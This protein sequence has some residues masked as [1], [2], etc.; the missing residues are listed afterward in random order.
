MLHALFDINLVAFCGRVSALVIKG[1]T[2]DV[3]DLCKGFDTVLHD[4]CISKLEIHGFD[5]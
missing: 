4:I 2:A 5:R 3:Q 1:R